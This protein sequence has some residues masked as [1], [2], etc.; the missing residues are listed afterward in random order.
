[1]GLF[2]FVRGAEA[3][4]GATLLILVDQ[5]E[6]IFRYRER[7]AP[8]E[9]DVFVDLLLASVSQREVPIYVVITMR[10]DYLGECAVFHGLPEAV[11]ESQYLTPQLTHD[12]LEEAITGPAQVF[13]GKVD[14]M[15][16][17]RLINDFGTDSDQLP[18]LQHA[19]MRLWTCCKASTAPP[20]L[21]VKDYKTIGGLADA[22]SNHAEEVLSDLTPAQ[23]RIAEVMFKRLSGC[24][25]GRRDVRS[26]AQIG[27]IAKIAA[28]EQSEVIAVAEAFRRPDRCFLAVPEGPLREYT[29]L[30]V[31][32]E[33]LIRQ[34]RTLA[35]WVKEETRSAEIYRRIRDWALRWEQ[36]EADLW[37]GT[38]LSIAHTWWEREHPSPD[39][40]ERYGSRDEFKLAMKFL[41]AS[42]EAQRKAVATEK[43]KRELELRR[44]RRMAW[45]FGSL[46]TILVVGI[47]IY[48]VA[49]I[50][51]SDSYYNNFVKVRGVP[52]G[53]GPLTANQVS[54]RALS[55]KITRR[56]RYGPVLRMQAVNSTGQP[57]IGS[58][59]FSG[60]EGSSTAVD[61]SQAQ[62]IRWEYVYDAK[63][64]VAHEVS[65]DRFGRRVR[66]LAYAPSDS[67]AS[68]TRTAYLIGRD[69]SLAPLQGLCQAFVSYDYSDK[70]YET[71]THYRDQAGHPTP[72]RDNATSLLKEY[73]LTGNAVKMVSLSR[74][75][76][77]MNDNMG[78]A[79][80]RTSWD[81]SGNALTEE[82]YDAGG[83]P[84]K[85]KTEG[86]FRLRHGY[87]EFGNEIERSYF[88]EFSNPVYYAK[89]LW[90]RAEYRWS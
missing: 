11:S 37:R 17:N 59:V 62:E 80:Y 42:E 78:N 63:E 39:W 25:R 23:R 40:A 76:S 65:L 7:I 31:S 48:Y 27:E 15:L 12:E 56:G 55:Y 43:E 71:I 70:G 16:T 72:G 82:A 47:L 49:K 50:M 2:E 89:E 84:I 45:G 46:A 54:H 81:K 88:D 41:D 29:L 38:D 14:P 10:S 35:D 20:S 22:L 1:L 28:A 51:E 75:G 77:R 30:D 53:I 33:S 32:H 60:F 36:D 4:P 79:E 64:K 13:G 18:L 90:H 19:L 24:E 8:D 57:T 52:E 5:F 3:L 58:G 26:P 74:D 85:L 69:G 73:D 44:A 68:N 9:A 83:A 34:W 66:T 67:E 21:T 6:E 87:D 86:Y 61:P